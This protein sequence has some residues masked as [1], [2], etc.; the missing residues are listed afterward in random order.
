MI[1]IAF[2]WM[3]RPW[4]LGCAISWIMRILTKQGR[5][6]EICKLAAMNGNMK[7]VEWDVAPF[8]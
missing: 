1:F 2:G 4:I 7:P 5:L 8:L 6:V 3:V